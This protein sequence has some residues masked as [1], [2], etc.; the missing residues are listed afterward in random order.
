MEYRFIAS[1]PLLKRHVIHCSRYEMI[2]SILASDYPWC[3]DKYVISIND[4]EKERV[5]M[6]SRLSAANIPH[7]ALTFS[8]VTYE[9]QLSNET[10]FNN[11]HADAIIDF[12]HRNPGNYAVHCF[13][14]V[15]RSA[16]V[17]VF[18]NEYLQLGD[19]ELTNLKS[20]NRHVYDMLK[21]AVVRAKDQS[22]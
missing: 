10:L 4:T 17:A 9:T 6:E 16:A 5:Q 2:N 22:V 18:L 15:S 20:F 19:D 3:H 13:A 14:G 12:V 1:S 21:A 11:Q 7:L 8:D